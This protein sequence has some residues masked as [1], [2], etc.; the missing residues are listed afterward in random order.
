MAF[1]NMD[2]ILVQ[3]REMPPSVEDL[4]PLIISIRDTGLQVPIALD[5]K[6]LLI[7]GLRRMDAMRALGHTSIEAV[8]ISTQVE[9]LDHLDRTR[10][11]GAFERDW[12]RTRRAYEIYQHYTY[13]SGRSRSL[14]YRGRKGNGL[15]GATYSTRDRIAGVLGL[16]SEP[17]VQAYVGNYKL[18]YDGDTAAQEAIQRF[19]AGEV[20]AYGAQS[21]I[22]TLKANRGTINNLAD[23]RAFLQQIRITMEAL[24]HS[25]LEFGRLNPRLPKEE[26]NEYLDSMQRNRATLT[27]FMRTLTREN[28]ER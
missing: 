27:R 21:I 13:L 28:T 25:L 18:L 5:T 2:S 4:E 24:G 6:S 1:V 23:Q 14:A 19:E 26:V 9:L 16:R 8:V 10:K 11:H 3:P 7:D 15:T 20:G 17:E 12:L 22:R